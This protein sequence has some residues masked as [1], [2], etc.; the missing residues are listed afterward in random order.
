MVDEGVI[1]RIVE[2]YSDVLLRIA[3]HRVHSYASAQDIVQNVF[4]KYLQKL[5]T[6]H[7]D[8]HE[9]AW[10]M[11]VTMSSSCDF[12]RHW[13]Q[14]RQSELPD[15]IALAETTASAFLVLC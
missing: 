11:R 9:R 2:T 7:D 5:P 10:F 3:L 6:F 14:K 4:L 15:Q 12:M 13:W 8:A 1:N